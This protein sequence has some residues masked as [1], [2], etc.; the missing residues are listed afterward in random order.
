MRLQILHVPGCPHA[1]ALAARLAQL[2][3]GHVPV[4]EQH[5]VRDQREAASWGM[6]GSPTLLIDGID[7]FLDQNQPPS[8]SCRLYQHEH[9]ALAGT[10]S[11]PQLRA[12]LAARGIRHA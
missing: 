1:A 9:G 2:V 12:A 7:P 3:A 6:R 10:P 11:L 5:A 4:V 8:L